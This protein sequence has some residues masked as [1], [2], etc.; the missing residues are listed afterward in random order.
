MADRTSASMGFQEVAVTPYVVVYLIVFNLLFVISCVIRYQ[1]ISWSL[2]FYGMYNGMPRIA[3]SLT[4]QEIKAIKTPGQ[5]AVGGVTGLYIQITDS[6]QQHAP[7]SRSWLLRYSVGGKRKNMG[8]GS[9]ERVSLS[10]ARDTARKALELV[11]QDIDPISHK[12]AT[13]ST[14]IAELAKQKT[15]KECAEAHMTAFLKQH[16]SIKHQK[17]WGAT[18]Q[19]YAYPIIGNILISDITTSH[20]LAVLLQETTKEAQKGKL[21]YLKTETAKRLRGRI[22]NI[23]AYA[24]VAGY[25][26]GKNPAE[27]KNH[28][29]T[30]LPA[31]GKLQVNNHQPAMPYSESGVFIKKL[32]QKNAI[33]AKALEFLI[34][35]GVRSGSVREA[36]WGEIDLNKEIW[37]IPGIHTKNGKEHRV[38]LVPQTILLLESLP[39]ITG[40]HKVFPSPKG[41]ALT[42]STLSKLMRE[43]RE[44]GEFLSVGVPHGFRSTF[45]DWAAEQTN[46]PEELRKVATMHTVGDAV[47]QAYQ[48]TDL[49]EKRR[50]LMRD[51]ANFLDK[52]KSKSTKNVVKLRKHA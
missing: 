37:V 27:W 21:W 25:R 35:T 41:G 26:S 42:D 43:M 2:T 4:P 33:G 7:I 45:R 20:V 15:F 48:R 13:R 11:A 9:Y 10:K 12:R 49:L 1:Q 50:Y 22:E 17:Q 31:P 14:L 47:Q 44:N 29:A 18:L 30:Q 23:L 28:L 19:Q 46:Y 5:H 32:R 8:L 6:K 3:K 16:K 39:R 52:T 34:L 38:P 51:W 24:E 36:E 40:N